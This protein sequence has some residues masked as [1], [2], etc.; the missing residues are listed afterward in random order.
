MCLGHPK[1]QTASCSMNELNVATHLDTTATLPSPR[2]RTTFL[3][4]ILLRAPSE[5]KSDSVRKQDQLYIA[6]A[7]VTLGKQVVMVSDDN[8]I[9][10]HIGNEIVSI[11]L[12][13]SRNL[14]ELWLSI[15][16]MDCHD[17]EV[18][19]RRKVI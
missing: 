8:P 13:R 6:I 9:G 3:F 11:H 18:K 14:G 5:Q 19:K 1:W 12:G 10:L 17:I 4:V 2:A 16:T 15:H 7:M